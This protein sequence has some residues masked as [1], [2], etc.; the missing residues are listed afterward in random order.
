VNGIAAVPTES[1]RFFPV[2]FARKPCHN[3]PPKTRA[4][5]AGLFLAGSILLH[6]GIDT[7]RIG[8]ERPMPLIRAFFLSCTASCM[9]AVVL[10]ATAFGAP[11]VL[12]VC[13]IEF[14]GALA[15]WQ[16]Y[17]TLQGHEIAVIAP[18]ST[19]EQL[20]RRIQENCKSGHVKYLMLIGD[21]PAVS[22]RGGPQVDAQSVAF[23]SKSTIP[24]N[25]IPGKVNIRWGPEREIAS[26]TPYADLDGDGV[27]DIAVGRIPA[28]SAEELS[29][30]I[31]KEIRYEQ[32][33]HGD[34]EK[35]LNLVCGTGG[36]GAVTDALVEAAG[37]QVIQQTVP[38]DY[39]VHQLAMTASSQDAGIELDFGAR[40]RNQLNDGSLAWVYLGH[41]L[42]WELDRAPSAV[43]R[44]PILSIRDVPSLHCA[45][46]NPLAVL[47]ACY[48]GA[49][50]A[51][52]NC[53]AE[54]LV[55]TAEG[56]VAVI[57]ATRVTMPY[58]N[59]VIGYELLRACFRD[60]PATMGEI[61]RLA[62]QRALKPTA[63]DQMRQFLDSI[64]GSLSPEPVDLPQERLEHVLM[65]H[66]VGDPL[67]RLHR[68]LAKVAAA[69]AAT[70]QK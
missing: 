27:P 5:W 62:Q 64:A 39:Q 14:R 70:I 6:C 55:T 15:E 1:G 38:S 34:W 32:T 41:G 59:T 33:D 53:L 10:V 16:A 60:Q 69:S 26:D 13:P 9:V 61:V 7:G 30:V 68:P 42:P 21:V 65:Y 19:A 50:D 49:M 66:L 44:Q 12:V 46:H 48:A 63:N 51:R 67:L 23:T 24:T 35:R 37:R 3:S 31:H 43:G 54:E 28:H 56:P 47:I 17:R 29:A 20:S 36:F 25:Y 18:L 22:R 40:A 2:E 58:G 57:A 11:D 8:V 45:P 4:V 52:Q